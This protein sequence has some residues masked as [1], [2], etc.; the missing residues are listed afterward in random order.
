[1]CCMNSYT[2]PFR[3]HPFLVDYSLTFCS[4][5]EITYPW[6]LQDFSLRPFHR[7]HSSPHH[8]RL[9][10]NN[11]LTVDASNTW[12]QKLQIALLFSLCGFPFTFFL[13]LCLTL[14][15]I[16]QI[17]Y[18]TQVG[19]STPIVSPDYHPLCDTH[20]HSRSRS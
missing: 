19:A 2:R 3:L 6:T 14:P 7:P 1:M 4:F 20:S 8:T 17:Q 12:V 11:A 5:S 13:P 18:L 16:F 15:C 9:R 10:L